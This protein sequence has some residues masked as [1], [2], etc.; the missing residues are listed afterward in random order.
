MFISL[1]LYRCYSIH[2]NVRNLLNFLKRIPF[3]DQRAWLMFL[4]NE[5][6]SYDTVL[7]HIARDTQT[8][9]IFINR[10][11][12]HARNLLLYSLSRNVPYVSTC[13]YIHEII[14]YCLTSGDIQAA[15]C[16]L[17]KHNSGSL[18]RAQRLACEKSFGGDERKNWSPQHLN[19]H[20]NLTIVIVSLM[21]YKQT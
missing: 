1:F 9:S 6:Q 11:I 19:T 13:T 4:S 3:N 21:I 12:T 18:K 5:W 7:R 20:Y 10:E 2:K 16:Q 8:Y 14:R 17:G 15:G